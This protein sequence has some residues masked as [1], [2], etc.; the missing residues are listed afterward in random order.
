VTSTLN[1]YIVTLLQITVS[2]NIQFPVHLPLDSFIAKLQENFCIF[3]VCTFLPT[4]M[5]E[6]ATLLINCITLQLVL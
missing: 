1:Y 6:H 3:M 4:K 2:G 5:R